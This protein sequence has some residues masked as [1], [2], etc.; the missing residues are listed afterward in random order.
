MT[1][2]AL[3]LFKKIAAEI[4]VKQIRSL[5]FFLLLLPVSSSFSQQYNIKSYTTKNGLVNPI[6]N[7]IYLDKRGYLWFATQGGLSRFDGKTFVNYT[8]KQG[9]PG[10]DI[11]F[12][13]EDSDGNIW[14]CT[15]GYGVSKFDGETFTNYSTSNGLS[16][17][18]VYYF[19]ENSKKEKWFATYGGGISVLKNNK[20]TSLQVDTFSC[21]DFFVIKEDKKG[22]MWLGSKGNGLFKYDGKTFTNYTVKDGLTYNA[23]FTLYFDVNDRLWIGTTSGG[24]NYMENEKIKP[25]KMQGL[26][27]DLISG[28]TNDIHGNLW[29]SSEHGLIKIEGNKSYTLFTENQG[30]LSNTIFS[31]CPDSEG[32]LWIATSLGISQFKNEAF[33]SYT[34][35][36][37]LSSNKTTTTF[38]D[39]RNNYLIGTNGSGLCY[40]KGNAIYPIT[41]EKL[42]NGIIYAILEAS[43]G[44]IYLGQENSNDGVL[45]L[46]YKNGN[47]VYSGAINSGG[48]IKTVTKIIEDRNKNIW[49]ATYGIGVYKLSGGQLTHYDASGE[50]SSNNILTLHEDVKGNIWIGT[51][52]YGL[53]KFDGKTFKQ[54]TKENGLADNTVW[55]INED[56]KGNLYFGS[57]ENGVSCYNGKNFHVITTSDGLPSG[58]VYSI[59]T[60]NDGYLWLGTDK[61]LCRLKLDDNFSIISKRNY[62]ENDGLKSLDINQNGLFIDKNNSLWISTSN[63]LTVYNQ[64]YDYINSSPPK[65]VITDIRLSHQHPDWS[66][67]SDSVD[68]ATKLPIS[69]S[70]NYNENHFIFNFQAL[71]TNIVYYQYMMEGLDE[72]WSPLSTGNEVMYPNMPAGKYTFKIKAINK[73]GVESKELC[74]FSF[75]IRPPF[76]QTT[77]FY[78]IVI[79]VI[80]GGIYGFINYRTAQLA[81]EKKILEDKV[82]ERTAE[83]KTAN[84]NLSLAY[85][86]IT[87]SINYAKKIQQAILPLERSISNELPDHFIL[88]K[89]RDVV[90]GDFYWYTKKDEKIYIAACD[91][92]GHGVPGAFMSII[93]TSLLNE[94]INENVSLK[95]SDV[96]NILRDKLINAL[97]QRT[98]DQES[99][100]GMDMVLCC[101]D[102]ASN[103]LWFAG[104]NN[105]L[106]YITNNELNEFKGD[107]QPVGIHGIESKPFTNREI[108]FNKGDMI[109]LFS[110]GYPDQFGGSQGKKFL[111]KRFKE[112][113]I[114]ISK[115]PITTQ[116]L[117]LEKTFEDWKGNHFQVDDVLVIGVRL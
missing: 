105:P 41:S 44:K 11:I 92:T 36:E 114:E 61:G 85:H 10:N 48:D 75:E 35:K 32:N 51:Y 102:K 9:L 37:G 33:I 79:I 52:Q 66:K 100:D 80:S 6:V 42:N 63:G 56:S 23:I 84:S 3:T 81:K 22:N 72:D 74:S 57:N 17:D 58:L 45:I 27:T 99:K 28:I 97:K 101:I 4:P 64:K 78:A 115:K 25:F 96:L 90:S 19:Y 117:E 111:Y 40:F 34:V 65:I 13:N 73:D 103:T 112:I 104:A 55:S 47:Y 31:I 49:I 67:F 15:N 95:P 29:C 7:N 2:F 83:L 53:I 30:L 50:L 5:L 59:E 12:V 43:D 16:S 60:G 89:P 26:E 116:R 93:G 71:T 18:V 8:S 108:K 77:W 87:D 76:Y 24:L 70:F 62:D 21:K 107:K 110:D 91:C 86:E 69:P 113:L 1:L 109:Y 88:F 82:E 46:E 38:L 106:Y 39:S 20:F 54:F 14:I 98:G 68:K 94:T